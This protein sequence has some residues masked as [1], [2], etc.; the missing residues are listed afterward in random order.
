[1]KARGTRKILTW[2]L[3]IIVCAGV[4]YPL[5]RWATL[6]AEAHRLA[7][8]RQ[9]SLQKLQTL[10]GERDWDPDVFYWLGV[11]QAAAG[12]FDAAVQSLSRSASLNP[13]SAQ[14]RQALQAA[15]RQRDDIHL[16][17]ASIP[18]LMGIAA[19]N[20]ND[21]TVWYWLGVKLTQAGNNR[22][23]AQAL[24]R[25]LT[26]NPN[27]GPA[28][29]TL[30]LALAR[31]GYPREAEAQLLEAARR[32]PKL[33]FTYF[34]LGSLYGKYKR[35]EQA[36][37]AL[38]TA[39]ALNPNDREAQYLLAQAYGE[40]SL[41]DRKMDVLESLVKQEPDNIQYL[42]SL[43][44]VYIFFGKFSDAEQTYRRIL[45]LQPDD[46]ETHYL[47]GRALAEQANTPEAFAVAEKELKA[48]VVKVPY[49]PGIYLAL[50]ILYF[51]RNEPARAVPELERAI[52]LG[53]R[54]HKTWLYLGQSY[55]RVGRTAEGRRTL[56]DFQRS[57]SISR[58]I[59][60]LEN[61]L[62]N[63]PDDTP[64]HKQERTEVQLRLIR[65]Y[66][67]DKNYSRALSHLRSI[68]EREPK[69]TQAQRLDREC[70]ARFRAA[71]DAATNR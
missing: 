67:E 14:I 48:V 58:A 37:A 11:R 6:R 51:R 8:L 20:G 49:E 40:I 7:R 36:V 17:Q 32:D 22:R 57:T 24:D 3:I 61:R 39:T 56:A 71:G 15:A 2:S 16:R 18:Q 60:Q 38:K 53:V 28:R 55:M 23:A 45:K 10:A 42:K 30:G 69:N 62:L 21:P 59:S 5:A 70:E 29:A 66:M 12:H 9:A 27:S 52:K 46:Q 31:A 34:T 35:W 1:V 63:T 25:S 64:E 33:E 26:L 68:L 65:V 41:E 43:G 44:Y 47:L 54:E 13:Q 4:A 19:R 50:G